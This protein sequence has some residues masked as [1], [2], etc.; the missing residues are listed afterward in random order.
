MPLCIL[1]LALLHTTGSAWTRASDY[2]AQ[3]QQLLPLMS[4]SLSW[5]KG[6]HLQS[7]LFCA[8]CRVCSHPAGQAAPAPPAPP[9]QHL[10]RQQLRHLANR[11]AG[12]SEAPAIH[13]VQS[14]RPLRVL[15]ACIRLFECSD[16]ACQPGDTLVDDFRGQPGRLCHVICLDHLDSSLLL[17][18]L[19]KGRSCSSA[20][21]AGQ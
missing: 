6:R 19:Q 16:S 10:L 17:S 18:P 4:A 5:Q 11:L 21:A 1:S 13:A 20:C 3:Q 2:P 15:T 14:L 12:T 8:A 9:Q 7:E